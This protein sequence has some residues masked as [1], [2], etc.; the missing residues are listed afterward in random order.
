MPGERA[1][2]F[3]EVVLRAVRFAFILLL[4]PIVWLAWHPELL[5]AHP[6]VPSL[7][8][9]RTDAIAPG[10]IIRHA[11]VRGTSWNVVDLT[12]DLRRAQLRLGFVEGGG[13]LVDQLPPGALA[14]VNGAYFER[15]YSP[16]GWLVDEGFE[17]H[18]LR[19]GSPHHVLA[20]RGTEVF[21]GQ[22]EQLPFTPE[23]AL[24]NFPWLVANGAP[25][26]GPGLPAHALLRRGDGM[27]RLTGAALE[28]RPSEAVKI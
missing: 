5:V 6:E 25:R 17:L 9:V 8:D 3:A 21:V 24:Q 13:S 14:A 7:V 11:R 23:F 16:H 19:D 26:V 10:L 2:W 18:P 1:R 27:V 15:D 20:V 28:N 22:R 12:V 4:L